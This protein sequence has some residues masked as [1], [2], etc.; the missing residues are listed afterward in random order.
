M[1]AK[2]SYDIAWVGSMIPYL[3]EVNDGNIEDI[4]E[5][6]E[7][8]A[9][10]IQE[11]METW[12]ASYATCTY[13][14]KVYGIPSI[15]PVIYG[16]NNFS[17]NEK[18]APYMD[19]EAL[20]KE[21]ASGRKLTEK[22]LD[23]IENAFQGAIDD[24]VLKVGDPSWKMGSG[25][26]LWGL[27]GY[28]SV[29]GA[30]T[31]YV[32]WDEDTQQILHL[33]EV[34]E[35]Q[36]VVKRAAKWYDMGWITDTEILGQTS[37]DAVMYVNFGVNNNNNWYGADENGIKSG[38]M[39]GQPCIS[40]NVDTEEECYQ[41]V[42]TFGSESTYLVIPY[43]SKNPER[44]MMLLNILRDKP[45]TVGNDLLNL[46]VYG[47]EETS[48]EAE[49]YGWCNYTA[50]EVDGQLVV[51]TTVRNGANSKHGITNWMI[52]NTYKIMSDGSALLSAGMKEYATDFYKTTW[53]NMKKSA[54]S[55]MVFDT[56]SIADERAA[57]ATVAGEY[58]TNISY[59]C[60][61]SDKVDSVLKEA[62][63]KLYDAGFDTIK[64]ELENQV[65]AN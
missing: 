23:I 14:D 55:G 45:G 2:T 50:V 51:D 59:G 54:V 3:N 53:N 28:Q 5:L 29:F 64:S 61:G 39:S 17:Y 20:L 24:G 18:L 22:T 10:N 12:A 62:I 65:K 58:Y 4:T 19:Q 15:Q 35:V 37:S 42:S 25:I 48:D 30:T 9:P 6:I 13:E 60:G 8:Y 43:T 52:S 41:R 31:Q 7:E 40:I 56:L 16:C 1:G 63:E 57:I 21:F 26:C 34:P 33:W 36:M 46:L 49:E 32:Y 27:L 47:F 44:A 38:V 11:E